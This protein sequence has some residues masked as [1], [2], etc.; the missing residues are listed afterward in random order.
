MLQI[1]KEF[2][3][4]RDNSVIISYAAKAI[5][6]NIS[7]P[8]VEQNKNRGTCEIFLFTG[9]KF[10][11]QSLLGSGI[12]VSLNDIAD[13]ESPARLRDRL[14]VDERNIMAVYSC[15]KCKVNYT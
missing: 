7:S 11:L 4:L 9:R 3:S 13:K 10:V 2:P 8:P 5:A 14:I 15:K 12:A 1:L 6:V